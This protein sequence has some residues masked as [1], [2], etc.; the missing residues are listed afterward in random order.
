MCSEAFSAEIDDQSDD[1]LSDAQ[2]VSISEGELTE[3]GPVE[4]A[5]VGTVQVSNAK[6]AVCKV[7]HGVPCR[8]AGVVQCEM[9]VLV[10]T[11]QRDGVLD[12][13]IRPSIGTGHD[14]ERGVEL[15]RNWRDIANAEGFVD[16]CF[17]C[18]QRLLAAQSEV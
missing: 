1:A 12:R 17:V 2:V 4:E 6:L 7:D 3:G 10:A 14:P 13:N 18:H 15:V 16:Q 5:T 9:A 11:D 8:D